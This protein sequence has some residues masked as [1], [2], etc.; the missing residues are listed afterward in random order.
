MNNQKIIGYLGLA[1]RARKIVTGEEQVLIT[2]RNQSAK[3]VFLA[4]DAGVNTTKRI[5]DKSAFYHIKLVT[6]LSG[7]DLSKA[8]GKENRKLIAITDQHF[9][10]MIKNAIEEL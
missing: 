6:S 3:I 4:S 5:T 2:I 8:I 10:E 7:S 1:A 9:A